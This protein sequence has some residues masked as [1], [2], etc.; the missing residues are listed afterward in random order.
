MD[1]ISGLLDSPRALGAFLLRA[2]MA[3]PWSIRVQDRAPIT[4]VALLRGSACVLPTAGG[5]E[6]LG[7]GDVAVLRG[8]DPYTIADRPE[9]PPSVIVHPDQS[10]TTVDGD[11]LVL[12]M[13]LGVRT[14]G[15]DHDGPDLMLIG[16]YPEHSVVGER[17]LRALPPLVVV[18]RGEGATAV[19]DALAAE[20]VRDAP[21]QAVV[22]DRLLDLVLVAAVRAWCARPGDDTPAWFRAHGDPVVGRALR[23]VHDRPAEPWTV[24]GLAAEVGVSRAAFA[25]RFTELVGEP[26]MT[27]LAGWRMALAADALRA[28]DATLE[29]VARRVGYGGAFA[30]STA[31]RR[32]HGVSPQ[33]YRTRLRQ[34]PISV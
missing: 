25:R 28:T 23:L 32:A 18:R 10:C 4:V 17:L 24:A 14:W 21:G 29:T 16:T 13:Q 19:V 5:T 15:N 8:P 26:P 7:P 27:Y 3:P 9:T 33:A 1:P 2:V 11:S 6:L 34:S 22:L 31:F 20:I 30:L 12:S